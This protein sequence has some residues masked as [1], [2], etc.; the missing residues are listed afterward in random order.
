M[1]AGAVAIYC[2]VFGFSGALFGG[3]L[4]LLWMI[5]RR[6]IT[7]S[8]EFPFALFF[9]CWT[10]FQLAAYYATFIQHGSQA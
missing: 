1:G 8:N 9:A 2:I 5:G 6:V 10:L 7:G 3:L 4:S